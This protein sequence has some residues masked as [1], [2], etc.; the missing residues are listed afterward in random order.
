MKVKKEKLI[1]LIQ[2]ANS[3]YSNDPNETING[4]ITS[5]YALKRLWGDDSSASDEID[6]AVLNHEQLGILIT[7]QEKIIAEI[8]KKTISPDT[9]SSTLASIPASVAFGILML[10]FLAMI[11]PGVSQLYILFAVM[12][13]AAVIPI[14]VCAIDLGKHLAN[15]ISIEREKAPEETFLKQLRTV[16]Q[17]KVETNSLEKE[18]EKNN[19]VEENKTPMNDAQIRTPTSKGPEEKI[20]SASQHSTK[21]PTLANQ[22]NNNSLTFF[23]KFQGDKPLEQTNAKYLLALTR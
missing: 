21:H 3:S 15:E 4:T 2:F 7:C 23:P 9:I 17:E 11:L 18:S 16:Q 5:L 1:N 8:E 10:M 14:V 6:L 13:I 22:T 20:I 12:G 19:S